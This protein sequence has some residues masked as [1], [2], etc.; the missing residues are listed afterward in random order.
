MSSL[1]TSHG[2]VSDAANPTRAHDASLISL[3]VA[4]MVE[5]TGRQVRK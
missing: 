3:G 1:L 5:L 2:Y 4:R